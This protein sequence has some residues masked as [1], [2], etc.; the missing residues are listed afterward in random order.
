MSWSHWLT[1]H[2]TDFPHHSSVHGIFQARILEWVAIFFFRGSSWPRDQT[3]ISCISCTG[4]Q[5][6]YHCATKILLPLALP[7][8][9]KAFCFSGLSSV[10]LSYLPYFSSLNKI[11][12]ATSNKGPALFVSDAMNWQYKNCT[13]GL[14]HVIWGNR[15]KKKWR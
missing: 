4:R 7:S 12:F 9:L 1:S 15:W 8:I 10:H 6:P 5:I 13:G 2:H 14:R 11:S 3:H